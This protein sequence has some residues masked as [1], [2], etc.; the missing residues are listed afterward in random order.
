MGEDH[1]GMGIMVL[2]IPTERVK[3][4]KCGAFGLYVRML[5]FG[6]RIEQDSLPILCNVSKASI[7]RLLRELEEADLIFRSTLYPNGKA[8]KRGYLVTIGK[9]MGKEPRTEVTIKAFDAEANAI[10]RAE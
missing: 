6:G 5:V 8:G 7:C 10:R 3:S 1:S 4:L 2:D 9:F